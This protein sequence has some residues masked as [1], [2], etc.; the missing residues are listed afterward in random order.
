MKRLPFESTS[1]VPPCRRVGNIDRIHPGQSTISRAAELSAAVIVSVGA[2]EL[3]LET[4]PC[5]V[6][7][8]DGKPLFIAAIRWRDIRP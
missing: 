1:S 2:P 8:I 6:G 4:T 7:V 3:I 5:A